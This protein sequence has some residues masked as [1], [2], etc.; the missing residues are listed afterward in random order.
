[1]M[2]RFAHENIHVIPLD[3]SKDLF[4]N[5]PS[6]ETHT[7]TVRR[8][9]NGKIHA[10]YYPWGRYVWHIAPQHARFHVP[11]P[12]CRCTLLTADVAVEWMGM[13]S[14]TCWHCRS[15]R[16]GT[17]LEFLLPPG[18]PVFTEREELGPAADYWEERGEQARA[19]ALRYELE[20][21]WPP[22][23][24]ERKRAW[25]NSARSPSD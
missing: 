8:I 15:V 19:R 20:G 11:Q 12:W 24:R 17:P 25:E 18:F 7:W 3:Q 21:P 1:M 16:P 10:T 14:V 2:T 13:K 9:P 22:F 5:T 23:K 4:G 6:A